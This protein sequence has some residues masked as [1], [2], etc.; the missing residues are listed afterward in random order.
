MERPEVVSRDEW[1]AARKELLVKEKELT[2]ARDALSAERRALPMVLIDKEYVFEGPDGKA[3][4]V[5]LFD[6]RRQLIVQHF[7]WL[8]ETDEGC[9][10]CSLQA[11]NIGDLAHL[12]ACD[13]TLVLVSRAPLSSIERFRQRMGWT[14]P[15][16]SSHG[17]D[18]NYDFH[19]STDETVAA[20]EFNYMDKA[21]LESKGIDFWVKPGQDGPGLS[22]FRRD[23][24]RVFH[25]YSTFARGAELMLGTYNY[26]DLTPLG[27]VRH[28]SEFPHHDRYG[29][30]AAQAHHHH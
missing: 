13:T 29:E 18:F 17:S 16:F 11:D 15:W 28:V 14:V 22:V 23:G 27:R 9:P 5:D 4:L 19:V 26:L 20:P 24:D 1:L 8:D 10:S 2:R 30:P 3:G 21:T 25:T 6:G 12:H 7:M